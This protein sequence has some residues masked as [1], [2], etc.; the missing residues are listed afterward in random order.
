MCN[1]FYDKLKKKTYAN[2]SRNSILGAISLTDEITNTQRQIELA[3]DIAAG[4]PK[5]KLVYIYTSGTTGMPKAAVITNLRLV[6][7]ESIRRNWLLINHKY[8]SNIDTCLS[9]SVVRRC[10]D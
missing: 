10:W 4:K 5:D 3:G 1:C 8:T 2:K 9:L 7:I 6:S